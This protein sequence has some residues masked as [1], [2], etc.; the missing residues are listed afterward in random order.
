MNDVCMGRAVAEEGQRV[1]N[2]IR[3][4][5]QVNLII[6]LSLLC[7]FVTRHLVQGIRGRRANARRR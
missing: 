6:T 5:Q 7:L 1:P 2:C 4:V 3:R